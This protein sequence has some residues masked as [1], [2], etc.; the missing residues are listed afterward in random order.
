MVS[1]FVSYSYGA[2]DRAEIVG[3]LTLSIVNQGFPNAYS[4]WRRH[5]DRER[6]RRG[7]L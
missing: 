1:V 6:H 2:G 4:C 3:G 7:R 5:L